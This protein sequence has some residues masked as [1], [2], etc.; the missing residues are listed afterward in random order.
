MRRRKPRRDCFYANGR[1]GRVMRAL[2]REPFNPP[3]EAD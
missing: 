1:I 3:V 2:G